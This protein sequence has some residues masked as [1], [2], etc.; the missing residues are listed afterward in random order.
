MKFHPIRYDPSERMVYAENG[1]ATE[2]FFIEQAIH[3][4]ER[5]GQTQWLLWAIEN[6]LPGLLESEEGR[7]LIARAIS[8]KLRKRGERP[9]VNL[10]SDSLRERL[11]ARIYFHQGRGLAVYHSDT[12][13]AWTD[14]A[15]RAV[16]DE[17]G[18]SE[19][20]A[21]KVWCEAG[22]DDPHAAHHK[23]MRALLLT[24]G[25]MNK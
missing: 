8:G 10:K 16:A 14:N 7:E 22:R 23:I 1:R 9:S 5:H 2:D 11:L 3:K 21:Y 13:G 25:R 6:G 15:C 20:H 24:D 4:F 19:H 12:S 18:C 17:I